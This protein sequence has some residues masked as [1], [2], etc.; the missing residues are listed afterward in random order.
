RRRR[1]PCE[2]TWGPASGGLYDR[3]GGSVCR[4]PPAPLDRR[5]VDRSVLAD[6]QAPAAGEELLQLLP[7]ELAA[8]PLQ[9]ARLGLGQAVALGADDALEIG[10][11]GDELVGELRLHRP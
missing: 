5:D 11:R 10:A 9:G 8:P 2:T 7:D 1:S 3:G 6:P 4:P